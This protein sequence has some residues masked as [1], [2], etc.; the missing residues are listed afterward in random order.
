MKRGRPSNWDGI[1]LHAGRLAWT[2]TRQ[3]R[4]HD[5]EPSREALIRLGKALLHAGATAEKKA[6]EK[7]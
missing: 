5:E 7:Q 2:G 3:Y 4:R 6:K 1:V